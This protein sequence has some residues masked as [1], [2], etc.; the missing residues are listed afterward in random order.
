MS[1]YLG[2]KTKQNMSGIKISVF[3][4]TLALIDKNLCNKVVMMYQTDKHCKGINT[5][6]HM[7]SMVFMQL[8]S[9]SSIRDIANGLMSTT[10]NLSHLG[11]AKAPSKSFMSYLNKHRTYEVSRDIYFE[12]LEALEP[13]LTKSRKY[14]RNLRR[15]IYLMDS[16]IIPLSLS[17][18]DWA[19]FRTS[20]GAVKL[21]TV[22][23]YDTGLPCYV[24][25]SE[26]KKHDVT[27]A[28]TPTCLCW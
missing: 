25:L 28:M 15:K 26:T 7:I 18:F 11:I 10:S 19:K 5:W 12:L 17:L 22:L 14:A 27:A 4:Q 1:L 8:S 2:C 16:T 24:L 21:N 23:D 3:S 9:A 13:S 20:K 6:T